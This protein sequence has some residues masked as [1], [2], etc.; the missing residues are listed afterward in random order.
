VVAAGRAILR[1]QRGAE[2]ADH[3]ADSAQ[4]FPSDRRTSEVPP[5]RSVSHP[6]VFGKSLG[7]VSR[8]RI[9]QA[10]LLCYFRPPRF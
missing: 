7:E 4:D 10:H 6:N 9:D 5:A 8:R 1:Q 3:C 2:E